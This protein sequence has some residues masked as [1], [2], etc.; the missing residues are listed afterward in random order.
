MSELSDE[1]MLTLSDKLQ[2]TQS[3]LAEDLAAIR[4]GR[5]NPRVLDKITV[6]YYGVDTPI[7][8]VASVTVQEG[9]CLVVTPWDAS[10]LKPI[11][12]A[13]QTSSLGI[14]PTNDGKCIR[15]VFPSLTEERRKELCRDVKKMGED[16]KVASRNVRR[17]AMEAVKRAK[18]DKTMSEDEC[19]NVESDIEDATGKAM[20]KIDD[21]IADKEKEI[22]A[23]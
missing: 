23:V 17:E 9:R 16:A 21:I 19:S 11:E 22:M 6:S 20:S 7:E 10:L 14:T 1:I 18:T 8:Q 3:V 5:A 15:L 13:L 2:K 12:K 4:A